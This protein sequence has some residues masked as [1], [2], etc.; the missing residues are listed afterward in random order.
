MKRPRLLLTIF[1]ITFSIIMIEILYTRIFTV[2]YFSS[3]AFLMISLALFGSG[4]GGVFL[5]ISKKL[6]QKN[7]TGVIKN[8][9]LIYGI[10]IP[11]VYKFSISFKIDFLNLFNPGSNIIMLIINFIFLL[12]PFFIAGLCLIVIFYCYS[13]EIGK[14]YF[15]DLSGAGLGAIVVIPLI[16]GLGPA[17]VMLVLSFLAILLWFGLATKGWGKFLFFSTLLI[18]LTLGFVLD[19]DIF[20]ILPKIKKRD[21][22][23]DYHSGKIE[24][25]QWSAINKIDI[26]SFNRHKKIVWLNAGTQQTWLVKS[27]YRRKIGKPILWSH[28]AIPFQLANNKNSA[29]IIGSAGGYEVLVALTN[30]FK[31]ILAVEM[32]PRLCQLVEKKYAYYIGNIFQRPGVT[33]INDEGRSVLK[34]L[35]EKFDVIQMVNSHPKDS[36]L[37]GGLSISETYIYTVE[38]F[39]DYWFH[40][41]ENGFLSIVHVYGERMFATAYQALLEMGINQPGKKLFVVQAARGFNYFFLK[42]GDISTL[43]ELTLR[44]FGRNYEIVYSPANKTDNV[45]GRIASAANQE[46]IGKSAVNISPSYDNSPYFNHPNKIGQFSFKNNWIKGLARERVHQIL[47][48]SNS[49]Y[50]SILGLALLLSLLLI[51]LPLKTRAQREK[52]NGIVTYFFFI[53]LAFI[54]VEIIFIKIFQLFLGNPVYSIS[55]IIF[56]LLISSGIGSLLSKK[57]ELR[58]NNK[59]I[60]FLGALLFLILACYSFLLFPIIYGSIHLNLL[61]RFLISFIL[62]AMAGI[63]M[64]FF[65]PVGLRYLGTNHPS[66]IGWAWGANAFAS[67]LGSVLTVIIAIN[68]NFSVALL[69]AAV[70]YLSAGVIFYQKTKQA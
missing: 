14:L 45:Y 2:I 25:S 46:T 28:Q 56:S 8:L 43:D 26:A 17:R 5:S 48:Y 27:E 54:M 59:L 1:F 30:G 66:L 50:F 13:A 39:K 16:S 42:K 9:L 34:R 20:P 21:F 49:V 15:V 33:L 12:I 47:L 67:I 68:W 35:K 18:I 41:E 55:V 4:L 57:L 24:L 32:D 62:L 19:T 23:S 29:L 51:Y 3:F 69:F 63:P 31:K 36:I 40:L 58:F 37:S 44:R 11:L 38:S 64:G 70:A 10:S 60:I 6:K 61:W 52:K 53:G 22:L 7:T 65:F